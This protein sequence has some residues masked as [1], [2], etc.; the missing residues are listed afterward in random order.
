MQKKQV[1]ITEDLFND[2]LLV[3]HIVLDDEIRAFLSEDRLNI[4][5]RF[6][7]GLNSKLERLYAHKLYSKSKDSTLTFEDKEK[8]INE[9][10]QFM[11]IHR[12]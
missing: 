11:E 10:L 9:Y 12:N 7:D 3:C 4:V 2:C 8:A 6:E 5:Q 1:Q